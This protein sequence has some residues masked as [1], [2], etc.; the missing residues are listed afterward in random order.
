[1]ISYATLT[2]TRT[3]STGDNPAGTVSYSNFVIMTSGVLN[4]IDEVD[5]V[6]DLESLTITAGGV[7]NARKL[8]LNVET[9]NAQEGSSIDLNSRCDKRSGVGYRNIVVF[10]NYV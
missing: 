5:Y 1:M 2:M 6:W 4:L 8:T 7:I 9:L 3:S 10:F